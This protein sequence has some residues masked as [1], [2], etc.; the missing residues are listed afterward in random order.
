MPYKRK[1]GL[2]EGALGASCQNFVASRVLSLLLSLVLFLSIVQIGSCVSNKTE[3]YVLWIYPA[4]IADLAHAYSLDRSR[5]V[6]DA[7]FD[8][9]GMSF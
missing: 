6:L 9:E 7:L 8:A 4:P 1:Y 5:L 2:V 3:L